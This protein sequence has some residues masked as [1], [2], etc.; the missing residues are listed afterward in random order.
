[1]KN[2][3]VGVF[4]LLYLCQKEMHRFQLTDSETAKPKGELRAHRKTA[5][6]PASSPVAETGAT[7]S[8]QPPNPFC[9]PPPPAAKPGRC[10]RQRPSIFRACGELH[11][12]TPA[13]DCAISTAS[14]GHEM[15]CRASVAPMANGVTGRQL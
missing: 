13:S 1:M 15:I 5:C 12:A 6:A 4:S 9:P 2:D 14:E 10:R 8:S 11:G 7:A 3:T